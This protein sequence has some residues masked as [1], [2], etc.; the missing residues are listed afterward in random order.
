M[1]DINTKRTRRGVPVTKPNAPL[2]GDYKPN[3]PFRSD[4]EGGD[5]N[6]GWWCGGSDK[7]M[8][9]SVGWWIGMTIVPCRGGDDVT[10]VVTFVVAWTWWWRG[11]AFRC[12]GNEVVM[13]G[14]RW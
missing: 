8:V 1:V 13:M 11:G 5:G 4:D 6:G 9:E 2:C 14:L 7:V 10:A 3:A 12:G